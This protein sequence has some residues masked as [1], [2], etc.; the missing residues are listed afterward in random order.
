[1]SSIEGRREK[2][3]EKQREKREGSGERRRENQRE[4]ERRRE[5]ERKRDLYPFPQDNGGAWKGMA[6]ICSDA[7]E[8]GRPLQDDD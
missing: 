4:R 5:G 6:E 1:M 3:R 7:E 2:G 8:D